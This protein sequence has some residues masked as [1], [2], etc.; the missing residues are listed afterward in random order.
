[1]TEEQEPTITSKWASPPMTLRL[2]DLDIGFWPVADDD[3][4]VELSV[5]T[6]VVVLDPPETKLLAS[7]LTQVVNRLGAP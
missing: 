5:G 7:F 4:E 2:G 1:M 3:H 6:D